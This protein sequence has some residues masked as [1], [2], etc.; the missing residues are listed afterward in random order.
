VT[1]K[2]TCLVVDDSDVVR[3]VQRQIIEDLG[4]E[5]IEATNVV[6]ALALCKQ[7]MPS[8]IILDWLTNSGNSLDFIA[9]LRSRPDGKTPKI[10]YVPTDEDP[11]DIGRAIAMGANDHMVKPFARPTLE[12]KVA[13]LTTPVRVHAAQIDETYA[14][15]RRATGS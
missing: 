12:A 3:R 5:V 4:F 6:D 11:V 14:F 1:A 15:G 13:A 2:M 7:A 10:L 8:V 9:T